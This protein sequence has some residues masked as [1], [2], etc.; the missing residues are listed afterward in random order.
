MVLPDEQA[1]QA[2]KRPAS[3]QKKA[4]PAPKIVPSRPAELDPS[5]LLIEHGAFR[6]GDDEALGQVSFASIGPL[7]SGVVLASFQEALP[8]LQSGQ[9]LT[10]HGLALLI[11]NAPGDLQTQLTWSTIRFAARCS[12]NQEPMLVSGVLVQLGRSAVYQIGRASCR[13]RV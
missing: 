9:L 5:K 10:N 6:V 7:A 4:Q 2:A 8:F 1:Q 13:E 12:V 3:K 11:L